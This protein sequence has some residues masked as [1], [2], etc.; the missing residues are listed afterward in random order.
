M[1]ESE[2]AEVTAGNEAR[3]YGFVHSA[4]IYHS[5]QEFLDS[6]SRFVGDGLEL[7]EAVLLAVPPETLVLLHDELYAGDQLPADVRMVDITEVAR[8]PSRFMAMEGAFIDEHPDQRVRIVSQLAWPGRSEEEFVACIEHEALVNEAM[9]AYPATSLCLYDASQLDGDVL[10]DARATHPLLWESGVLQRSPAYAPGDVLE[11]CNQPLA[12]NPGAVTYMV[13]KSADLRPARS[14]AQ[15]YAGW[16]GVSQ[17]SMEDLQ[18]VATELATNS[19]MY[20][21]G[22]CR[23]AFWKDDGHL[24]C[25][26]RDSGRFDDPL[27]GRLD[28]G[29]CGPASRGLYLVNALSDLVRTHTTRT[30]TTIQAYLR[31]EPAV[32]PA[33]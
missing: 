2:S 31:F 32:G 8:N 24:V 18:L 29:P 12:A 13:R 14:F 9:D 17:E 7:D 19:L 33:G 27:V 26:A 22:A 5:R 16:M 6:V 21:G 4:L 25:E 15:D 28:P 1:I 20:T 10:A 11:R 30:G 3:Q 23:L